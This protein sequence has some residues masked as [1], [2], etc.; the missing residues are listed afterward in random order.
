MSDIRAQN[1]ITF[2]AANAAI[3]RNRHPRNVLLEF[4]C[5]CSDGDCKAMIELTQNEYESVR[6]H[7][8]HFALAPGHERNEHDRIVDEFD[9]YTLVQK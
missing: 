2:R 9:R 7:P 5:E 3:D 1:E 6:R 8:T 4:L